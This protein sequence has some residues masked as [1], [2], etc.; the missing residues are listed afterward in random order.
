MQR[1]VVGL[2]G[3]DSSRRALVWAIDLAE[4][5][6]EAEV[7][8]LAV[9]E[10]VATAYEKGFCTHTQA[11]EWLAERRDESERL[12]GEILATE[13]RQSP[14]TALRLETVPGRPAQVLVDA[15]EDADLLCVGPRGLG[16]LRGL[17]GSVSQ[18]CVANA[19][20]PVVVVRDH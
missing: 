20:C 13:G 18:A 1:I 6:G 7:R 19:H 11:E 14:A 3:S 15:S 8:V 2:D 4:Q 12:L 5:L 16:R 17:L 9:C 10:D